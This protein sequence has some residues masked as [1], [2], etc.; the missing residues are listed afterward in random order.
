MYARYFGMPRAE[1]RRRAD[2]LLEFAQLPERPS[3]RWSRCRAA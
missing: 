1:S 3:R 2:E